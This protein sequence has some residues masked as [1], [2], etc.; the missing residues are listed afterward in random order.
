MHN[1]EG[2]RYLAEDS[3]TNGLAFDCEATALVVGQP[4]SFTFELSL[5]DPILLNEILDDRLLLAVKPSGKCNAEQLKRSQWR[6]YAA[7]QPGPGKQSDRIC[8]IEFLHH[9][10]G[11]MHENRVGTQFC[12]NFSAGV[13]FEIA[14]KRSVRD[15]RMP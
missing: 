2:H 3:P 5:Q 14:K 15:S 12:P 1:D 8:S 11:E 6:Q 10:G 9:T 4:K 7:R 13:Q